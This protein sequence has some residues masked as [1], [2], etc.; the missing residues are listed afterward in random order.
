VLLTEITLP[1]NYY[2]QCGMAHFRIVN[3]RPN[4]KS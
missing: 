4:L 2:T 3:C 1:I